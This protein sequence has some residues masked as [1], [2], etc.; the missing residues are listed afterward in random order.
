M[1]V[2]DAKFA[3]QVVVQ[4]GERHG[5]LRG[6]PLAVY[7]SAKL[8]QQVLKVAI[9]NLDMISGNHGVEQ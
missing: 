6:L 7:D 1:S 2:K 4:V 8:T 9:T 3:H 5:P